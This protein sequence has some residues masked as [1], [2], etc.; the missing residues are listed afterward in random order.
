MKAFL[1]ILFFCLPVVAAPSNAT[2]LVR[3]AENH[4]Q[5]KSFRGTMSM[6]VEHEG[7]TRDMRMRFWLSGHDK[8]LIKI[9]EPQKDRGTG[10]LRLN[11][12]LW[13]YLPNVNR[14]I[15]IPPSMMLQSWMGSDFTNDDL[16]KASSLV[17]DY[18]H[19]ILSQENLD[20]VKSIKILLEPKK[21]APVVWGK[22]HMWVR[23]P[24]GVPLKQEFYNEKGQIVKVMN[25]SQ[26]KSFG[27]H[28]IPTIVKMTNVKKN[29]Q[30][31]TLTYEPSTLVFDQALSE[32]LFTQLNLKKPVSAAE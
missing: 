16:V 20:G 25:G 7:Q 11:L 6:K 30:S 24:D 14:T 17:S 5:G 31:T 22:I 28:S 2:E 27:A 23:D 15:R 8:A 9:L 1:L 10:N 4:M 18:T 12:E 32:D 21:D 29:G 13:Q 26:I 19:K 3:K